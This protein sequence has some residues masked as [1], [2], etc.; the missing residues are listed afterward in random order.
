MD[1]PSRIVLIGI[2]EGDRLPGSQMNLAAV[3]GQCER[4]GDECRKEMV[5]AVAGRSVGMA[6]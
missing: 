4:R 5:G 2:D 3:N 1:F 6:I